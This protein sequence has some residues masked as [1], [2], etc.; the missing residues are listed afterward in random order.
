MTATADLVRKAIVVAFLAVFVALVYANWKLRREYRVLHD[1]LQLARASR[2]ASTALRVGE[3]IPDLHLTA[4]DGTAV[5]LNA[6]KLAQRPIVVVDPNCGSCMTVIEQIRR[7]NAAVTLI[8]LLPRARSAPLLAA[9]P[10]SAS[11]YFIENLARSGLRG[12]IAKVPR[13]LRVR[14][15]GVIAD[16][17][18]TLESCRATPEDPAGSRE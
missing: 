4:R 16:I 2:V 11:L 18:D 13:V 9:A 17:C 7:S 5:T 10:Q 3:R 8:S 6:A 14:T 12:R 15:D 1:E